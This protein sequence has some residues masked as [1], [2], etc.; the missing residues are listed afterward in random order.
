MTVVEGDGEDTVL[1]L[2]GCNT[3]FLYRAFADDDA[4]VVDVAFGGE[5]V[6]VKFA[7]EGVG[8]VVLADRKPVEAYKVGIL[9]IGRKLGD[10]REVAAVGLLRLSLRVCHMGGH[11]TLALA[12]V[13]CI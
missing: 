13:P 11:S 3:G 6:L 5:A 4:G 8:A 12:P 2:G 10:Q 1:D 9:H 7:E